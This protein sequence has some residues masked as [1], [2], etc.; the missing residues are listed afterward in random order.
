[1]VTD[2][3]GLGWILRVGDFVGKSEVLQSGGTTGSD[4]AVNW[5][6][7]RIRENDIVFVREDPSR[8]DVQAICHHHSASVMPF[9]V[10]G[11]SV[12]PVYQHGAMIGRHVPLWDSQEAFGDTNM[13]V[14]NGMQ[15]ASLAQ[16]LGPHWMVLMRHHGADPRLRA[17]SCST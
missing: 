8:P 10:A 14:T 5:R 6:V 16:A 11:V 7:D 2:P 13:L 1:M 4:V 17:R 12:V 9:S 15:G 3:S